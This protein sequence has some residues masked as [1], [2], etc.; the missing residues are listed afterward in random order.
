MPTLA[1]RVKNQILENGLQEWVAKYT[2]VTAINGQSQEMRIRCVAHKDETPSASMS[3]E[4]GLWNCFV[5]SCE[6]HGDLI[7]FY[8]YV[9]GIEDANE[10]IRLLAVDLGLIVDIAPLEVE[11]HHRKLMEN[12]STLASV[13]KVLGVPVET[14][15]LFKI[16][17]VYRY[18]K[19]QKKEVLF[20]TIPIKG[21]SGQYED[22]RLYNRNLDPKIRSWIAGSGSPKIHPIATTGP[23]QTLFLFEGEKDML[24]AHSMGLKNSCTSTGSAGTLPAY[25]AS[26][27]TGKTVYVC[28]DIDAAGQKGIAKVTNRLRR[29]VKDLYVIDLPKEGLP[30]NGDFSDWAN[31]G[32]GLEEWKTLVANAR[33]ITTAA[34]NHGTT[35]TDDPEAEKIDGA[36]PPLSAEGIDGLQ[37]AEEKQEEKEPPSIREVDFNSLDEHSSFR[38][39]VRFLAY[40][41]GAGSTLHTYHVAS[42]I[43]VTCPRNKPYCASCAVYPR[44][45]LQ[46]P[47]RMK[48]NHSSEASLQVIRASLKQKQD[49]LK[50]LAG[51][52]RK[53]QL[54]VI[55][56]TKRA[57]MQQMLLS[58]PMVETNHRHFQC[59]YRTAYFQ[60]GQLPESRNYYC[61]GFVQTD[62]KT[63]EL[64]VNIRKARP[65][66]NAIEDFQINEAVYAALR[67]FRIPE[68]QSIEDHFRRLHQLIENDVGI[69]G[70]H[71]VQM[72]VLEAIYSVLE[73][74]C[75][76]KLIRS[77]WNEIL[78]IGD[79]RTGKSTTVEQMMKLID[80]GEFISCENA[81]AAGLIGGIQYIDKMPVPVWGAWP[82]NHGRFIALDEI[83]ALSSSP[84]ADI[85]GQISAMRSSGIAKIQKIV[86]A[87]AMAKVR[88]VWITNPRGGQKMTSFNGG[89]NAIQGVIFSRQD[90]SRFTKAYAIN[91]DE[92]SIQTITGTRPRITDQEVRSFFNTLAILTWSLLPED[93][94][95]ELSGV[96]YLHD[97]A[98]ILTQK[99]HDGIPLI[100][101]GSILDKLAKLSIPIAVLCGSFEQNGDKLRLYVTQAHCEYAIAHLQ[102]TY[103]EEAMGYLDFSTL[104]FSRAGIRDEDEVR[105]SFLFARGL[106]RGNAKAMLEILLRF[107]NMGA[108][109]WDDIVGM[110]ATSKALWSMMIRNHCLQPDGQ[111]GNM[112]KTGPFIRLIKRMLRDLEELGE[113]EPVIFSEESL[114]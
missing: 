14:I 95:F 44:G 94:R 88:S 31:L 79:T 105:D 37:T 113:K 74:S 55:E 11:K 111:H 41:V 71:D 52:P 80:V 109:Q 58:S 114:K 35:Y 104:E 6:A 83:D 26:I 5:P 15:K 97:Q 68:E 32:N 50:E 110:P 107:P 54:C 39:P 13:C 28:F 106:P 4:T 48:L 8:S 87:S 34:G 30:D 90:I 47:V 78:V 98:D 92:V 76:E 27:F 112:V 9:N 24:R 2:T 67:F 46:M 77:G 21:P 18:V 62:P 72:A 81:S 60:G 19:E 38:E 10:A 85:T 96:R 56:E 91:S 70:R 36:D 69:Y 29:I 1:E 42:E 45:E 17:L 22:I 84:E 73:F 100:E 66:M 20:I 99:Y 25:Y 49:A 40:T 108:R 59:T 61:D 51:I 75:G 57:P 64:V 89:I 3:L 43:Q 102:K 86:Q 16:G 101:K 33:R 103:D 53:C 82:R 65:A 7:D 63:Q 12:P 93:V 23:N